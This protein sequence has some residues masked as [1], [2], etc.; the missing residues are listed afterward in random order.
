MV[1]NIIQLTNLKNVLRKNMLLKCR[2]NVKMYLKIVILNSFKML[3]YVRK[4]IRIGK[5]GLKNIKKI[6][7]GMNIF[8]KTGHSDVN[9]TIK[10]GKVIGSY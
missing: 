7:T 10:F 6:K 8:R 1:G 5:F 2:I 4:N 9:N 3:K